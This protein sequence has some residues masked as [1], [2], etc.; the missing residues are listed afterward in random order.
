M[1]TFNNSCGKQLGEAA[2]SK[3][4]CV[5]WCK[6]LTDRGYLT[7]YDPHNP[8]ESPG[9]WDVLLFHQQPMIGPQR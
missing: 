8:P 4:D 3:E 1:D 2:K 6:G 9:F 7:S 5:N